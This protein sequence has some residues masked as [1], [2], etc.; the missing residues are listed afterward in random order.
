MKKISLLLASMMLIFIVSSCDRIE[1]G[2]YSPKEKIS[3][4]YS[5]DMDGDKE[6]E[7]VWNWNKKQLQSIDYYW[8][9]N[10][11]YS[12]YY[13]YNDDGRIESILDI[14]NDEKIRYEYDDEKL[15]KAYYYDGGELVYK[16]DFVY[17]GKKL[18][19]IIW[20]VNTDDFWKKNSEKRHID[21]INIIMPQYDIK[22]VKKFVTKANLNRDN[23]TE[24]PI[25]LEWDNDN[26]SKMSMDITIDGYSIGIIMEF[27]Y[28]D[29]LNP[30]KN[31]LTLYPEESS[32]F[33]FSK[34]NVTEIKY[35]EYI[36][37]GSYYESDTDVDYFAY[38]Y[39]GKYPVTRDDGWSKEYF[40]YK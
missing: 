17:D 21:P 15:S 5:D 11:D 34:N 25:K 12:E 35:T 3:K 27:K 10:I 37:E 26:V 36:K 16:Y 32:C 30:F 29:K 38:T 19:K 8:N 31:L 4:I 22:N 23:T 2:A 24:L 33:E 13:T 18:S 9:D 7:S 28:D 40:E 20:K 6:L 1:D 14:D 39:D